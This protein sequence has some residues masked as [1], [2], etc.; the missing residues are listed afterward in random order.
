MSSLVPVRPADVD[1]LI[2]L[3][4]FE[5]SFFGPV[6]LTIIVLEVGSD[7]GAGGF[8]GSCSLFI[9][10][11]CCSDC[12]DVVVALVFCCCLPG[13]GGIGSTIY[14]YFIILV[15]FSIFPLNSFV[16]ALMFA[17]SELM[18]AV[19]AVVCVVSWAFCVRISS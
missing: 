17:M 14:Y 13:L 10:P 3:C 11:P 7:G 18:R 12:S 4:L 15:G 19:S 6:R 8:L 16:R 1:S 2:C 9:P 5:I